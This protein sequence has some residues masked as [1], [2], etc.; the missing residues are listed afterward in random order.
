MRLLRGDLVT[1]GV[2]HDFVAR[3][4]PR[5]CRHDQRHLFGKDESR[6]TVMCSYA[7]RLFEQHGRSGASPDRLWISKCW[8]SVLDHDDCPAGRACGGLCAVTKCRQSSATARIRA[9]GHHGRSPGEAIGISLCFSRTRPARTPGCA[10]TAG[11]RSRARSGSLPLRAPFAIRG[12]SLCSCE[13]AP[14]HLPCGTRSAPAGHP[15]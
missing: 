11:R 2:C 10:A 8:L 15:A 5:L 7:A 6:R 3:Q 14:G 9:F 13:S 12:S 4:R 1:D